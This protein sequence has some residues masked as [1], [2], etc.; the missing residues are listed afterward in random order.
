MRLTDKERLEWLIKASDNRGGVWTN[1]MK[2]EGWC[3][4]PDLDSRTPISYGRTPRQ[5]IDLAIRATRKTR[6]AS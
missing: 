3:A 4:T 6:K 2:D 5:A 1:G